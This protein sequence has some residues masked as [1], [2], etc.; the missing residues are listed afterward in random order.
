MRG[1]C[2][3]LKLDQAK[4]EQCGPELTL[5]ILREALEGKS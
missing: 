1:E 5:D 4:S 2:G 3:G